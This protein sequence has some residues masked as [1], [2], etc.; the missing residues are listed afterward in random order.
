MRT[1]RKT[2]FN[3]LVAVM[4]RLRAPGGCPWDRAQ[5]HRSLLKYLKE[6]TKEVFDAVA[7]NDFKNLR[8]ELGDILLQIL[9][10]SD[11]AREEGHFTIDDVLEVLKRKLVHRHPHVFGKSRK[12]KLTPADVKRRWATL[13]LMEKELLK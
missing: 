10:H 8:E 6:E 13:K 11:M 9:F 7:K 4:A 2:T 5:T 3:D 12:E 1:P